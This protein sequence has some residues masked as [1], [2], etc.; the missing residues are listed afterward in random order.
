MQRTLRL[1][2]VETMRTLISMTIIYL[3]KVDNFNYPKIPYQE[4]Y[5]QYAWMRLKRGFEV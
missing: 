4:L 5:A 3:Y 1:N 2:I